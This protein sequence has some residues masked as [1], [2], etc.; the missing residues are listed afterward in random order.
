MEPSKVVKALKVLQDE[1][2]ED[3]LREGVLEEAWV[4]LRRPKRLSAEGV[5]AAVAACSSPV[6]AGRKFRVKSATGRKVARLPVSD[7]TSDVVLPGPPLAVSKR[8]GICRLPRRQG[9]SLR[10]RVAAGS[11]SFVNAAVAKRGHMGAQIRFAHARIGV[12][13]Q[14]RAPY[15]TSAE[16]ER[17]DLEEGTLAGTS[18]MAAPI[19][20]QQQSAFSVKK[21]SGSNPRC[22]A[23]VLSFEEEVVVISDDEEEVQV[24]QVSLLSKEKRDDSDLSGRKGGSCIQLIPRVVSPML[25]R[26][27]SWGISNQANLQLGEQIELV[28]QDGNVFKGTVCGERCSS[29]A[30]DR[31]YVSLD[32]SKMV[33]GVGPSGCDTSHV[34]GEHGLQAIHQRSGRIVGE[35]SLPVKV[36]APSLHRLE[37]RVKPGAVY[38]TSGETFGDNE[39][40]PSTS[41]GAGGGLASME[42]ELL[43]YDEEFEETVSSRHRVCRSGEVSGEV[44][45][46][47]SKAHVQDVT[48]GGFPR[49]RLPSNKVQQL[50]AMLEEA[51]RKPKLVLRQAQSLL[52]HLNF[53][54][55]VVRVGRAFCRRLG[56]AM[57]GA[58]LPHHHIRLQA[59]VK[60][61]LRMWI[62]F[63]KDFNGVTMLVEEEDWFCHIQI[64]SD[65]SGAHGF[66]VFWDG[67]W[68]AEAW[69]ESWKRA[70]F[71]IAFLE[72]FPLVV[73]LS[74]WGRLLA[75]RNVIFNVDNQTVVHL[76]NSQ[77]AKD[78]KVLKLLRVFLL[79]CLK[80]N[81][82]FKARHV[83]G[84]NN[85]IADALS[86]FQW[87]RFRGLAPGAD[88][89]KT[90]IP[91]EL[92]DLGG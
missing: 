21:R 1:G 59:C 92:W 89:Q 71:S 80:F 28:D 31:A 25:H 7:D 27:Q 34:S 75:N 60:E 22:D 73:A 40:E 63:L 19:E 90:A 44:Q 38:P 53:A 86:R 20:F 47:P 88:V 68:A 26:V 62:V 9:S 30:I 24:S 37:G 69:P 51:V 61:D 91:G 42:E 77:K 41:R 48:V 18:K 3:L 2:R 81:I 66:G 23:S 6:S 36:R 46:G 15:K 52:G 54:C 11:R 83:P 50:I 32:L 10:S 57:R 33:M 76:V 72:F 13:N 65:A 49:V 17:Q 74:V 78:E 45:G 43:D 8:R 70:K 56:F 4:G 14:A 58:F 35:Q 84:I 79:C 55:K 12:R 85:D 16:R 5:S 39:S 87:Q 64:F 82:L 29:G 67:H